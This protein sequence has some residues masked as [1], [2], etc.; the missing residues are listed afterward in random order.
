MI[1]YTECVLVHLFLQSYFFGIW[2]VVAFGWWFNVCT[3]Q[4]QDSNIKTFVCITGILC[5]YNTE[6]MD[7]KK[8]R[9]CCY[10]HL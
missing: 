10:T 7:N 4:K 8:Y 9:A 5:L 1:V 2:I 6:Y 3:V